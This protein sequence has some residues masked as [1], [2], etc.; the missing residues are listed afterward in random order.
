MYGSNYRG[1][2]FFGTIFAKPQA[3]AVAEESNCCCKASCS[4]RRPQLH[5]AIK[6][7]MHKTLYW[8]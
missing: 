1:Y 2:N 6:A 3:A 8:T 7:S 4:T 5:A